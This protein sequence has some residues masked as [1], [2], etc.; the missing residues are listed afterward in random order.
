MTK[1]VIYGQVPSKS[2]SYRSITINGINKLVKTNEV[3]KYEKS[4]LLQCN[5]Y[6]NLGLQDEF[7][8][9]AD[10]FFRSS[11]SD[12]DGCLKVVLDCLQKANAIKNDNKCVKIYLRK[13]IDK[14][15][16]RIEF[17]IKKADGQNN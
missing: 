2:N 8:F 15:N 7:Y 10:I 3:R 9:Y 16:P 4:F 5:L 6:R 14:V 13:Y 17:I 12:L 1:Q 11:K